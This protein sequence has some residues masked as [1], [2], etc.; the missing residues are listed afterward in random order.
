MAIIPDAGGPPNFKDRPWFWEI[1]EIMTDDWEELIVRKCTQVGLS[2]M[3]ILYGA[4]G[5]SL[6]WPKGHIYYLPHDEHMR[7]FAKQKVNPIIKGTPFLKATV[8]GAG[9]I[10]FKQY[11]KSPGFYRGI[12]APGN[13]KTITADVLI[14]DE[15]DDMDPEHITEVYDR[16][17]DST[18]QKVV[19]LGVPSVAGYG[20]DADFRASKQNYW[21]IPCRGCR[22][23][24]TVED[25]WPRCADRKGKKGRAICPNCGR[26]A[27]VKKGYW[28][29]K[30]PK[31]KIPGYTFNGLMNPNVNIIRA[32][33]RYEKGKHKYL[34]M[35]GFLGMPA[36]QGSGEHLTMEE[37]LENCA[38]EE[39]DGGYPQGMSHI[40]PTWMG[41]DTGGSR[42]TRRMYVAE[43]G[44]DK[45]GKRILWVGSYKDKAH[46]EK[47]M[48]VFH[49]ELCVID[50][51]GEPTLAKE[52]CLAH[53]RMVYRCR[54]KRGNIIPIWNE[55]TGVVSV[56]R[57]AALDDSLGSLYTQ[58]VLPD[59]DDI[60]VQA[61]ASENAAL[62]QTE[63]RTPDGDT[64]VKYVSHGADHGGLTHTYLHLA[65]SKKVRDSTA[66][67]M[68]GA[69]DGGDLVR[70]ILARRGH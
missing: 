62:I 23:H 35:R 34:F 26:R 25:T 48:S 61:F 57:T 9:S 42:E 17:S 15:R 52:L 31:S 40:G 19:R 30:N 2:T 13:R 59:P 7:P 1:Y 6:V 45:E 55:K 8:E 43:K 47:T 54:F 36:S 33:D 4:W 32:L 68:G 24:W 28:K 49:V 12:F 50:A 29:P 14:L 44:A 53:P 3:A 65:M 51:G 46:I 10:D 60:D 63:T 5:S 70:R 67:A 38:G 27:N 18:I 20:I 11:L 41:I 21:T 22:R 16:I 56:D 58:T 66:K 37:I 39:T 64:I 69:R